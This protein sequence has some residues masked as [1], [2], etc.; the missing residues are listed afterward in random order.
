MAAERLNPASWYQYSPLTTPSEQIR[1]CKIP[2]QPLSNRIS[3]ELVTHSIEKLPPYLALSYTWGPHEELENPEQ[4][5]SNETIFV[6]SHPFE[7]TRN[8][9]HA[10]QELISRLADNTGAE[11]LIW[12]DAICIDLLTSKPACLTCLAWKV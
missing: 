5:P 6:G 2:P 8:L 11:V 7:V 1:L 10:L 9:F 12:I 4:K 3:R